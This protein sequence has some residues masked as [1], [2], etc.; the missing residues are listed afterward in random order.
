MV[1]GGVT[2]VLRST[3]QLLRVCSSSL[4]N[5]ES[6]V[7]DRKIPELSRVLHLVGMTQV[8]L[9]YRFKQEG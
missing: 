8:F 9:L 7:D 6:E 5:S 4:P 2:L 3:K 1:E